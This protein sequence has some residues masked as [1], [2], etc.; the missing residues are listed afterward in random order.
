MLKIKSIFTFHVTQILQDQL[1]RQQL[2]KN[3]GSL[4]Q[5]SLEVL[6]E[7]LQNLL[8]ILLRQIGMNFMQ[9]ELTQLVHSLDKV[10]FYLVI[11]QHSQ[12]LVHSI[13]LTFVVCSLLLRKQL[14]KQLRHNSLNS[15]MRS[16]EMS[17][18][19]LFNHS[20]VTFNQ[21]EV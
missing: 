8:G 12:L 10:Q 20:Y 15:M 17:S 2:D 6:L 18:K 9:I 16:Q 4:Q 11:K 5:D 1:Q 7:T 3:H 13:E 14:K 21:E 19:E